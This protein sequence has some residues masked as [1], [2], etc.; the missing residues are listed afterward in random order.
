MARPK[1]YII[2]LI[3]E[4]RTALHKTVRN[5]KYHPVL[6]QEWHKKY[7]SVQ[8]QSKFQCCT[9]VDGRIAAR[10]I[11]IA[12][13]AAPDGHSRWTLRLLDEKACVELDVPIGREAHTTDI[14]KNE[15]R[16]HKS[17]YWCIPPKENAE[18]VACMEDIL[19]IYEMPYDPAIPVVCMEEKPYQ[20]LGETRDPLPMRLGDTR[21]IDSEFVGNGT[22]SLFVFV[23]ALGGVRHVRF[24]SQSP[25]HL[26]LSISRQPLV[27]IVY[28]CFNLKSM[29]QFVLNHSLLHRYWKWIQYLYYLLKAFHL[30]HIL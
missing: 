18:F 10:M 30:P 8:H 6:C 23:E 19:D 28:H 17:A 3:E 15:L 22:C 27:T 16:P 29:N 21:K 9:K 4:E 12:C 2:K 24:E 14:K 1:T 13:G 5:K 11:Q 25:P 20:L 7:R 26:E